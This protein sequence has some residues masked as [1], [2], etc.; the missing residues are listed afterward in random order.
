VEDS[1]M[2]FT[3]AVRYS[4]EH[5]HDKEG[6]LFTFQRARDE[7]IWNVLEGNV[8]MDDI[9]ARLHD[10]KGSPVRYVPVQDYLK[11]VCE[12]GFFY[13]GYEGDIGLIV[14]HYRHHCKTY[15][16]EVPEVWNLSEADMDASLLT[17]LSRANYK[18]I[19]SWIN[20]IKAN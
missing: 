10:E 20:A 11:A 15:G 17:V 7:G 18:P 4:E 8:D 5:F 14:T 3:A 6:A 9:Y 2:S 13:P 19:M 12:E 16:I 1:N